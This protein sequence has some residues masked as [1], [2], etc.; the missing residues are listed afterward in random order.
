M[1]F[2]VNEFHYQLFACDFVKNPERVWTVI[3]DTE[4]GTNVEFYEQNYGGYHLT[5]IY[6]SL[7]TKTF[8]ENSNLTNSDESDL[9]PTETVLYLIAWITWIFAFCLSI[10]AIMNEIRHCRKVKYTSVNNDPTESDLK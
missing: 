2:R 3:S 1:V 5:W 10:Y 7:E 6:N 9:D 8:L 4:N